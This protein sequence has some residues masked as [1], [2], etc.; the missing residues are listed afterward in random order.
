MRRA[1]ILTAF[2][3]ACGA[4]AAETPADSFKALAVDCAAKAAAAEQA[5]TIAVKAKDGWLFFGPE[6][7]HVSVGPFWGEAAPK[8]SR[9]PKPEEADPMPA[10]LDF[11]DQLDKAGIE[12]LLVPVPPKAIVYPDMVCDK[13]AA[14]PDGQ[15]PRLDIHHQ[16]FY[17]LLAEKGVKVLDIAPALIAHRAD[18]AGPMYCKQDTHWSAQACVLAAKLIAGDIKARPWLKDVPKLQLA[19]ADR[20]VEITGDLWRALDDAALPKERLTLRVVSRADGQP[21]EPDRSSPLVL[22]GDSHALVFQAGNDMLATGAG[23]ADQLAAELGFAVDLIGVRGSGATPARIN[24]Y[25]RSQGNADYLAC[26][27]LVVWCMGAREFTEASGWRK[28]PIR[29][30]K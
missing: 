15:V 27:K 17:K 26:K 2:I 30:A 13:V 12:L 10:I 28:V 5:A 18:A 6:L 16:A 1:L 7:R 20:P 24:F 3:L 19:T 21:V 25:R 29:P 14:G 9:A 4:A 23:L 11:K 8:V 22:L